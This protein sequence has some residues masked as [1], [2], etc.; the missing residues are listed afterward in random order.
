MIYK[1]CHTSSRCETVIRYMFAASIDKCE[2]RSEITFLG[3][4]V[5]SGSR[6]GPINSQNIISVDTRA[7]EQEFNG[8]MQLYK[9]PG[10]K[11][12]EHHVLSLPAQDQLSDAQF[13]K[14][15]SQFLKAMGADDSMTWVA[16]KHADTD[17]AH[18]HI[19][20]C[21]VQ[22]KYMADGTESHYGL[23]SDANDYDRGVEAARQI[24]KTFGLTEIKSPGEDNNNKNQAS[25]IR[26]ISK[27]VF[28]QKPVTLTDF[29][30]YMANNGVE[31]KADTDTNGK[32]R[33]VMYR[34]NCDDGR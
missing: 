1:K 5:V 2:K 18:V 32:P 24:E 20:L 16:A 4:N 3:G 15:V 25:I 19:A 22:M 9:G 8:K 10:E 17:C 28:S 11:L 23:L 30:V 29:L 14:A 26:A 13:K 27:R 21:R 33:G 34:L 31:I 12:V 7:L 6:F